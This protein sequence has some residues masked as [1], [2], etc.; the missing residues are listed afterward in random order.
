MAYR[1]VNIDFS[2]LP[3]YNT[4]KINWNKCV[5]NIV[6]YNIEGTDFCG[7]IKINDVYDKKIEISIDNSKSVI[8]PKLSFR[9]CNISKLLGVKAKIFKY[10]I[11]EIINDILILDQRLIT[12]EVCVNS[13][14]KTI[15]TE[16]GYLVQCLRDGYKFEVLEKNMTRRRNCPIC[17][18]TKVIPGINDIGTTDPVFAKWI[19]NDSDIISHTR[20]TNKQLLLRCPV[21]GREFMGIPNRY[22]LIPS[23]VCND[24][25]SYPEKIMSSILIQLKID[26]IY[27]LNKRHFDWCDSYKYDF[28]FEYKFKKYIIEMDGSFH[29]MDNYKNKTSLKESMEIDKNKDRLAISNNCHVIRI[30]AN[31][32]DIKKRNTFLIKNILNSELSQLFDLS[33]ID[34]NECELYAATS[35]VKKVNDLWNEGLSKIEIFHTTN[36]SKTTIDEYIRIGKN[37]GL[38][39]YHPRERHY[40]SDACKKYLKVENTAGELLCVYLGINEFSKNSQQLIGIKVGTHQI[41]DSLQKKSQ[42]KKGLIFSYTTEEEY[43][44]YKN[45]FCYKIAN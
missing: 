29:Y 6:N 5:G 43:E 25:I 33:I 39:N 1:K 23:C 38:N 2:T 37:L 13:G 34:W 8:L 7:K 15:S 30:N 12:E 31:Y 22:K 11:G 26:Y 21:C 45:Q 3:V 10:S 41:Y 19:V 32:K 9:K 4:G 16:N 24:H 36:L 20:N 18:H 42:N 28:Y 40:I 44:N 27:Q 17:G 14:I 35:L